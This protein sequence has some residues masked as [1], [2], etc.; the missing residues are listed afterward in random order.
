MKDKIIIALNALLGVAVVILFILNFTRHSAPESKQNHA[1]PSPEVIASI[2]KGSIVYVNLDTLQNK[3]DM[4]AD[5]KK[6]LAEKHKKLESDYTN[7]VSSHQTRVKD[8]QDKAGKGLLLRSEAENIEKELMK[9][10]QE[11]LQ[12]RETMQNQLLEEEQVM[13]RRIANTIHEYVKKYNSDGRFLYVL[14]YAF[15]G[16]LLYAPDSLDITADIL[17]GLNEQYAAEHK[18]KLQK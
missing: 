6:Q 13:N 5:V 11:L 10:E 14:S 18:K 4:F 15:G 8:Y 12:L 16:N 17:K 9:E 2:P 3:F 1:V 7:R